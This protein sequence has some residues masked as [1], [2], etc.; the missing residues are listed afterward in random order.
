MIESIVS[1]LSHFVA[2]GLL[3]HLS[4]VLLIASSMMRRMV[5]LRLLLIASAVTGF[6]YDYFWLHNLVGV[7]WEVLLCTVN[8]VQ[9]ALLW[10][11]DRRAKFSEEDAM[12]I[13]NFLKGGTP[14]GRRMLLDLGQWQDLTPGTQ[15]TSKGKRPSHLTYLASGRAQFGVEDRILGEIG[16][17]HFI[18]EMS[19]MGDGLAS[20]D[21]FIIAESRVWQI[22][23]DRLENL[24]AINPDL[25][26]IIEAAITLNLRAKILLSNTTS[27]G[28]ISTHNS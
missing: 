13:T 7:F 4:Y 10:H 8:V 6:I 3:G 20:A 12:L 1:G 2:D 16:P 27:Q 14:G 11:R 23:R 24:R 5:I 26:R 28:I 15:L 22:D 9:L 18:G 21:V 25:F 19:L 17:E